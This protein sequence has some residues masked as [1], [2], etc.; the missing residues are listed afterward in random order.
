MLIL[1]KQKAVERVMALTSGVTEAT[2]SGGPQE[3]SAVRV[4]TYQRIATFE[5]RA[6][7]AP[8]PL[9]RSIDRRRRRMRLIG[10][11]SPA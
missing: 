5:R 7:A 3:A 4:R 9:R 2:P 6:R 1:D 8:A 10:D 11:P